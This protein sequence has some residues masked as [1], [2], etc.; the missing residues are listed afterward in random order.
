MVTAYHIWEYGTIVEY[1][2]LVTPYIVPSSLTHPCSGGGTL[3]WYTVPVV[4]QVDLSR[5]D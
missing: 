2:R 1:A 3:V 4:V 5:S